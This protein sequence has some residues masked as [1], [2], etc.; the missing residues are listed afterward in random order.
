M[1]IQIFAS[2]I[3]QSSRDRQSLWPIL[4]FCGYA[5]YL[6]FALT[7]SLVGEISAGLLLIMGL[8]SSYRL[9]QNL[10]SLSLIEKCL[11]VSYAMFSLVSI[12]SFFYWPQTRD[13]RMHLEDYITFV[14]LLPLYLLLRQINFEIYWLVRIFML[15][16]I[17]LGVIS[18][19]QYIAMKY[20]GLRILTSGELTWLRPSGDVNPMRYAAISLIIMTFSINAMLALRKKTVGLKILL[21]LSAIFAMIACLLTQVRGSWLA[22]PVLLFFYIIYLYREG[23]PRFLITVVLLCS[24]IIGGASQTQPLKSRLLL[25]TN[26]IQEY[27]HGNSKT[28]IGSRLDMF[29]AAG[30]LIEQNPIFG[31]GLNSYSP[32]ATKIRND[33]PGMSRDVGVWANP[34]NEILQVLVEKGIIGLVT[35][36]LLFLVPGWLFLKALKDT[37]DSNLAQ[38]SKFYAMCGITLLIVYAVA[39]QSVALFEHNV[40]NH[41]FALMVLLFASQIRVIEHQGNSSQVDFE[42]RDPS[43]KVLDKSVQLLNLESINDQE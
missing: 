8:A 3:E 1:N 24:A 7:V 37:V 19:I 2:F 12:L 18:I 35:L 10:Y 5:I 42:F 39:G 34:H 15:V 31:H 9:K 6:I 23:H 27:Y 22:I 20:F 36:L 40:F 13:A 4:I 14:M 41:F 26:N 21:V 33:T 16:A 32:L 28:S 25:I 43:A 11:L 17:F 30:V 38:H 29:K